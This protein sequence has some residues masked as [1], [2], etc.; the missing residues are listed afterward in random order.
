MLQ[1]VVGHKTDGHA[2]ERADIY[3]KVV[4][5]RQIRKTTKGCHLC[6]EWKDGT[7][8][9]E[10]LADLKESNPVEVDDYAA[11]KKLH[12]KPD[13]AWWV[14]HV[15]KKRNR[16]IA[17][18]IKRYHKRT[19]KFGIQVPKT[20]D[21]AV[22]LDEGNG[23]TLW[24]DAI[25]KEINNIRIAFKFLNGEEAI[26]PTYQE[27]RCH[28]IF[29]VKMED[30]R[31]KARFV[32]GGH[33]TDAPHVMTYASVVSRESVRIELTLAELNDLDVMMGDIENAYLTAPITEKVLTV[34]G[35]EF[36]DTA[37]K[38]ALI[39]RVLCGLKS[40]GA[41][42]RNH[43]AS[44]MD[45]LKWKPCLSDRDLWMKEDTHLDDGVKYR[46]YILSYIDDIVCVHHDPGTS[47]AH[48]D[49]YFKMKPGSIMEPT[50]YLGAKLKKTVMPNG[51]VA[52]GMSS[53]KYV[54]AAVQNVQEYLKENGDRKLNKKASAP[55][56]ATYRAEIDESPVLGPEMANYFQSQIG[57]CAGVWNWVLNYS[58]SRHPR[59]APAR[60][61]GHIQ[62][63]REPPN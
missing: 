9:W 14:P 44:C 8:S 38:R 34:I 10:R 46:A 3:V 18:V 32:A 53:S 43:L 49:K 51:V 40:A 33:T 12:D 27:I 21:E 62:A 42:F 39:V 59:C 29:N 17:A 23:K 24:Q 52:W 48:I 36:G 11:T 1:D 20:W 60:T 63:P 35:P 41:A 31:R 50:F 15:L 28:M 5:N 55:F 56:E 13:F 37:G 4:S 26:P 61:H 47:L 45:H 7:T 6:V 2:V 16:I 25:R 22:T 54:Q 30:F 19:H 58:H 57:I